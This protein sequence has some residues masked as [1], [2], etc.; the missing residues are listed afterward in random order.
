MSIGLSEFWPRLVGERFLDPAGCRTVAMAF[1]A[2]HQNRPPKTADELAAFLVQSGRMTLLQANCLLADPPGNLKL[3]RYRIRESQGPM[4]FRRWVAVE[5]A[6]PIADATAQDATKKGV[7][8]ML[9]TAGENP[10]LDTHAK[11]HHRSLQP[12]AIEPVGDHVGVVSDLPPGKLLCQSSRLAAAWSP[13]LVCEIGASLCEAIAALHAGSLAS[14]SVRADRVWIDD[15][16]DVMLLRDPAG[17]PVAGLGDVSGQWLDQA[18]DIDDPVGYVAPELIEQADD[19][20]A[21]ANNCTGA[22]DI[23]SLG[24]LMYRLRTGRPIANSLDDHLRSV[25][26]EITEALSAGESGDPLY[27]ILAYAIAKD[28]ANRF[29]SAEQFAAAIGAVAAIYPQEPPPTPPIE[30]K[31]K[32]PVKPKPEPKPNPRPPA[33]NVAADPKPV[34]VDSIPVETPSEAKTPTAPEE[35]PLPPRRRRRRKKRI[36]PYVLTGLTVVVLALFVALLVTDPTPEPIAKRTRPPMP[37][38]TP[39]LTNRTTPI[40]TPVPKDV[41]PP[42]QQ[43]YALVDDDRLL[44]AP[45]YTVDSP[46]APLSMLPPGPSAI[47]SL[48]I[49][50]IRDSKAAASILQTIPEVEQGL[51]ALALRSGVAADLI[52]RCTLAMFPDSGGIPDVTLSFE[53]NEAVP[54]DAWTERMSVSAAQTRDGLT[55]FAGD[56]VGDDAIYILPDEVASK[57]VTRFAIGSLD[58]ITEVASIEGGSIPLPRSLR[59]LWNASSNDADLIALTTPNFLFADGRSLLEQ[60]FPEL[61][62]AIKATLI[63]DAAGVFLSADAGDENVFVEFRVSPSGGISEASLM[64]QTRN[65]IAAWPTWADQFIVNS[66]PDPSWR[67]LASRLPTMTR[68]VSDKFRFGVSADAV[69]TNAYLPTPAVTQWTLATLL[70][71]NTPAGIAVANTDSDAEPLTIDEML[72]REMSVAF[73]QESLEFAIEAVA[74]E[75]ARGLP[76]T[77][78]MPPVKIIGGDLQKMGITQ[79]QQVRNFAKENVP[80]RTVLTDLMLGANPD[81]TATGPADPKQTLIW[82]V[83]DDPES[84]GEKAILVTTREAAKGRYELPTEFQPKP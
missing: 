33:K 28:P 75:F 52:R 70:A 34:A 48:K 11:I 59:S 35:T 71:A 56:A 26:D 80:L 54:L 55:I 53:L 17:P 65:A 63:P 22:S 12:I 42:K 6:S 44:F 60:S 1:A 72:D 30:P 74:G 31:A 19:G 37:T 8:V 9:R 73:D 58:R 77:S 78:Q 39:P 3:G 5:S 23:Y 10:W 21:V 69:V 67:L 51:N 68:F 18:G 45:M 46:I 16:G 61:M 62:P 76:P 38:V 2:E 27:R 83:A 82:V 36:A 15:N 7:T 41:S 66:V 24:C 43:G 47:V 4:P 64:R 50:S 79:N 40:E 14:G 84:P 25:P 20:L 57:S 13:S 81:R 49:D 29:A 32:T